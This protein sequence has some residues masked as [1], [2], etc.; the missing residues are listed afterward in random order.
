MGMKK[1]VLCLI[2]KLGL[3]GYLAKKPM[4]LGLLKRHFN[5]WKL[6]EFPED[7]SKRL[8]VETKLSAFSVLEQAE[9]S[10]FVRIGRELDCVCFV[11]AVLAYY[12]RRHRFVFTEEILQCL[13]TPE[14]QTCETMLDL[15]ECTVE[16]TEN[17]HHFFQKSL[18]VRRRLSS[19]SGLSGIGPFNRYV[20]EQWETRRE[21]LRNICLTTK[22]TNVMK[23]LSVE[24]KSDPGI[25]KRYQTVKTDPET[26]NSES[27]VPTSS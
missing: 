20:K 1:N 26:P 24:W 13:G 18:L 16:S 19:S 3:R 5:R 27:P 22:S 8:M 17:L 9:L 25:R 10:R 6:P 11:N 14:L 23:I 4:K 21:E 15:Y 2:A 7:L 12:V